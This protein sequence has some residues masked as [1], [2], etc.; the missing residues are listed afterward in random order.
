[1]GRRG[2]FLFDGQFAYRLLDYLESESIHIHI[3]MIAELQEGCKGLWI[4]T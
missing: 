1:L 2:L 3:A 4:Q